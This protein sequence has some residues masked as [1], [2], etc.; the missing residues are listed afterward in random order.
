MSGTGPG[1]IGRQKE[2]HGQNIF[3]LQPDFQA[4]GRHDLGFT[5][6][7]VP[8]FLTPRFHIAWHDTGDPD[9]IGPQFARQSACHALDSRL[10]GLVDRQVRQAEM[11]GD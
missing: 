3:R 10:G 7:R 9:S 6:R 2:G 5:V 1:V 4:L 8:F 11:P